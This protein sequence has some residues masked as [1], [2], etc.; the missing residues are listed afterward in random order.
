MG[1]LERTGVDIRRLRYF[2]AVCDHGGF[3][4]AASVTG[5]AQP[6]LTRQV[7]LLEQELGLNLFT[8]NGRNAVPTEPGAFLLR[9]ARAHL[10]GL[11]LLMDRMRRDFGDDPASMTLGICPTITPL[12]LTSLRESLRQH[13]PSLSLTVL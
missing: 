13:C 5:I 7:Q 4:K 3:S 9:H 6:A 10:D 8:R 11:D 1:R 2:V 12:F